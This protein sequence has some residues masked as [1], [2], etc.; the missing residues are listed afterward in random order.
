MSSAVIVTRKVRA[1]AN[2][3]LASAQQ[4][5]YQ[6]QPGGY[7][8]GDK[9]LGISVPHSRKVAKEYKE[10]SLS[11]IK[12]LSTSSFHEIRFVA[13]AILVN[14]FRAAKDPIVRK[15]LYETYIS[16]VRGGGIVNN[17]DLV[18]A[19][20]PYLGEYLIDQPDRVK[21]L[22]KLAKNKDLWVQRVA[23]ILTFALI[24]AGNNKPTLILAK[25]FLNHPHDLIHKATGWMLREVG[26]RDLAALRG[27]L[28]QH[29]HQM[30]RTM[31]RYSIEHLPKSERKRWLLD[32]KK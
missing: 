28:I 31:L 15:R 25:E 3:K 7:G 14:Q 27:F 5:F 8:A 9:F 10:L 4:G 30:P 17:W 11:E 32:S 13:L 16:M 20:A 1:L 12:R 22:M 18:D 29:V 26:K 2:K 19:S 6:T 21:I 24:R 23:I